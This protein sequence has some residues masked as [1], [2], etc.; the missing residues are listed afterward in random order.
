MLVP[1][2]IGPWYMNVKLVPGNKQ[3]EI[4]TLPGAITAMAEL[5]LSPVF[6]VQIFIFEY[7]RWW[8]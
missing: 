5:T 6:A 1:V 7:Q 4:M 2:D 8:R 3:A